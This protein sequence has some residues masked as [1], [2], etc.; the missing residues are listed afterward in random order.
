MST[1]MSV[2]LCACILMKRQQQPI[3]SMCIVLFVHEL[4][5]LHCDFSSR[6]L[7]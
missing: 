4:L 5:P 6:R 7:C 3:C 2:D 1:A